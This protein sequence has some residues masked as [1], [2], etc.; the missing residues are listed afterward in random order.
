MHITQTK[1]RWCSRALN[2]ALP[3]GHIGGLYLILKKKK[4][5]VLFLTVVLP[6][7]FHQHVTQLLCHWATVPAS[8][9][10]FL[11]S[12]IP[13]SVISYLILISPLRSVV[14]LC[15][16][17]PFNWM[18]IFCHSS[19]CLKF[20]LFLKLEGHNIDIFWMLVLCQMP[21]EQIFSSSVWLY[22]KSIFLITFV[23]QKNLYFDKIQL[24]RW[25]LLWSKKHL[26]ATKTWRIFSLWVFF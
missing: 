19:L 26:S 1:G 14:L 13:V 8:V 21:V 5:C 7:L 12:T 24:I 16:F 2:H 23:E 4:N 15:S 10:F 18:F 6:F 22:F 9:S 20:C 25:C 3:L 11:I 17:C